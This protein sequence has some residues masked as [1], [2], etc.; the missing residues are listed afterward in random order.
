[1]TRYGIPSYSFYSTT[2]L[3]S[4]LY[5]TME[6][7][8]ANT[9]SLVNANSAIGQSCFHLALPSSPHSYTTPP[10]AAKTLLPLKS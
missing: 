10:P 3:P 6:Q 5:P 2:A 1:M 8:H 7:L 4:S 9:S